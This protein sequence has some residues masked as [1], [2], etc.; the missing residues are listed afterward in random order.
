[1]LCF[2]TFTDYNIILIFLISLENKIDQFVFRNY[3][4]TWVQAITI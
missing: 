2:V 4:Q 1:M 3:L